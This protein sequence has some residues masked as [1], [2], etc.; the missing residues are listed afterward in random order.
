LTVLRIGTSGWQ[1]NDWRGH[2]YP[3]K[4]PT[5]RW[6]EYYARHFDTV[7]VNNTFYRLPAAKTFRDW[8]AR[9][10]DRFE[11]AIKASNYLTHY[12]RLLDPEEPVDR[13]LEHA[14][15]LRPKL[16][17]VLLQL[18]PNLEREPERLDRTLKAFRGRVRI[19]VE[20]RHPSWFCGEVR[21]VLEAHSA[22][23]C[24]ADRG[25]RVMTPLWQ[26]ADFT[27]VRF[28]HGRSRPPSCYG[29]RALK[30][31]VARL[32]DT[33]GPGIDGYAYFNNDAHGCAIDNATT[34]ARAASRAGIDVKRFPGATRERV[35]V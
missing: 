34:F 30:T 4:I 11:F 2:F 26:T 24:L 3:P 13:L 10:P 19:A 8:A 9:V 28:H 29:T 6:L 27:Y 31:G 7:E 16:G 18:P 22:A 12:K 25:S 33:F 17:V 35:E 32:V 5:T 23:I 1:Y 20:P 14:E 21:S 15:P